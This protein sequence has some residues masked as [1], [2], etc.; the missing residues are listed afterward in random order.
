MRLDPGWPGV[1]AAVAEGLGARLMR[2]DPA[3]LVV[4]LS[5]G[6]DSVALL[7]A[8]KAWAE[9]AGRRIVAVTV[10]H[11]LSPLSASWTA[12]CARRCE[13][14]GIVHAVRR[15]EGP[16][17]ATGVPAAARAA[18]HRLLAQAA[19]ALGARVV[20]MGHTADDVLEAGLMRAA[21]GTTAAPRV[22]APAPVW[23]DGREIFLL[24]PLLVISRSR[25]RAALEQIGETWIEDPANA[26]P[27][28]PRA[29]ARAAIADGRR[30][31]PADAP[32][33]PGASPFAVGPAGDLRAE[34]R[35]L[36]AASELTARGWLGTAV[37]CA[38]GA[39]RPP[40]S[41]ALDRILGAL[42]SGAP[43]SATLGGVR[44]AFDG[45]HLAIARETSDTRTGVSPALALAVGEP[46]VWDGRFEILARRPGLTVS[47]LTG[48][49]SR[50]PRIQRELARRLHPLA[51]RAL[52]AIAGAVDGRLVCP[53]LAES[54]AASI[55]CLVGPRLAAACG[56]VDHE[57]AMVAWRTRQTHPKSLG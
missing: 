38:A 51:R 2:D 52:P 9:D 22:W 50:M 57:S 12:A 6:G 30:A 53:T 4:A 15:W 17:P 47:A 33:A 11:G 26:D 5:G 25:L 49:M 27:A 18:R 46:A 45:E 29:R 36:T 39:S 23:P 28:S 16:R 54:P 14:L 19:R 55:R 42:R 8:T 41:E 24:R 20:L 43:G 31:A 21:G 35:A 34:A 40:R 32:P 56:Q 1:C 44:L 10:D 7:L 3:P 37:V 13:R 48:G